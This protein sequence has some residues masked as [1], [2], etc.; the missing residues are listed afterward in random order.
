MI[1]EHSRM[2]NYRYIAEFPVL[3]HCGEELVPAGALIDEIVLSGLK[4]RPLDRRVHPVGFSEYVKKDLEEFLENP[5]YAFIFREK[6]SRDLV[7]SM[8]HEIRITN[9]SV[10]AAE[11]FREKDFYTYRHML[12]V[13]ALSTYIVSLLSLDGDY[14]DACIGSISHDAG[15][16]SVPL[17]ILQKPD[18]LTSEE[19][20]YIQHHAVA[21]YAMLHYYTDSAVT[22]IASLIARDH[23]ECRNGSGYPAGVHLDDMMTEIVIACDIYDALLSPR[24]YR[25]NPFDNRTALE[26]IT[27]KMLEGKISKNIIQALISLNRK[28]TKHWSECSVSG[29]KRGIPPADNNY[30]LCGKG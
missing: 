6:N 7:F 30:G 23:H 11:Y 13:F 4:V 18:P 21:G 1:P 26:V 8:L 10:E 29:E 25:K 28:N 14:S 3:S 22:D 27:S 9:G 5:V 17:A 15:K 12:V 2:N 19:H 16:C 20:R 24:P